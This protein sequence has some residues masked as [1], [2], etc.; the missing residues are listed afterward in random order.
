[1]IR[2]LLFTLPFPNISF[3]TDL[4]HFNSDSVFIIFKS[5]QSYFTHAIIDQGVQYDRNQHAPETRTKEIAA[6]GSC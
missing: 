4:C 6:D 3:I 2:L 5:G 1:M